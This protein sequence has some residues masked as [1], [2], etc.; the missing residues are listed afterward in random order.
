VTTV[1]EA[2]ELNPTQLFRVTVQV[3]G[4]PVTEMLTG[5]QIVDRQMNA[6][7]FTKSMQ[8]VRTVEKQALEAMRGIAAVRQRQAEQERILNDAGQLAAYVQ[9]KF[10]HILSPQQQA[11]QQAQQQ[12]YPQQLQPHAPAIDPEMLASVG[13]VN[14]AVAR[15]I[16]Q[17][18]ADLGRRLSGLE[19]QAIA[20]A[21]ESAA[22]VVNQ[23]IA[24]LRTAH[25]VANYDQQID[26][27][28]SAL[29]DEHPQ[30]SA[31]PQLND[32]LRFEV[33]RLNPR[34]PQEMFDGI[35]EVAA[36]YAEQL[37]AVYEKRNATSLATRAKLVSHGIELPSGQ[38]P[39]RSPVASKPF[40][41][42]GKGDWD[43]LKAESLARLNFNKG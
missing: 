8:Q 26:R 24:N 9:A 20:R 13:D 17:Q 25:E 1:E 29:T 39:Q 32:I 33:S 38:A 19:H 18:E 23:T 3:D 7:K 16:A 27:H 36:A 35:R 42:N 6:S 11:Q 21:E 10:P 43:S 31:I 40:A 15:S 34:T 28:I 5:K 41:H 2:A 22:R 37:D 12:L 4:K 14:T 30:L